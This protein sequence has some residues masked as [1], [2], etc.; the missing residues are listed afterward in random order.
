[1][2]PKIWKED[3]VVGAD[4]ELGKISVWFWEW[5]GHQGDFEYAAFPLWLLD[6]VS[7]SMAAKEDKKN[8]PS[9]ITFWVRVLDVPLEFWEAPTFES[10][11]D[12]IGKIVEVDLDYSRVKIVVDDFKE[13]CFDTTIDF[14]VVDFQ[15]G[16]EAPVS[17]RKE[18]LFGFC[19]TCFSLSHASE[20]CPLNKKSPEKK[21]DN[22]V[23]TVGRL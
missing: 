15:K 8:Y 9:E 18:K 6:A 14:K 16:E 19:Q 22:R 2:L 3:R 20:K 7:G 1:M 17:L 13:L 21:N 4:L 12:A 5:R 23:E 10:I 11:E